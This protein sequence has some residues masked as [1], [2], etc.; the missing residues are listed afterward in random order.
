MQKRPGS[1]TPATSQNGG[2]LRRKDTNRRTGARFIDFS[3]FSTC[4]TFPASNEPF[5]PQKKVKFRSPRRLNRI[6]KRRCGSHFSGCSR[7]ANFGDENWVRNIFCNCKRL[8]HTPGC[9]TQRLC[10]STR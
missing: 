10:R 3:S 6:W 4:L 9:S 5:V 2:S 8:F 7:C 1:A